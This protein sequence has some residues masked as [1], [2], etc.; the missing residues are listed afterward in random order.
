MINLQLR[1][2]ETDIIVV[3]QMKTMRK[4][5]GNDIVKYWKFIK[6]YT[7]GS[8]VRSSKRQLKTKKTS[9]RKIKSNFISVTQSHTKF[10]VKSRV[11]LYKV[12]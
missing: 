9:R 8:L 11:F 4:N 1:E 12:N 10:I 7:K 6:E 5:L 2:K 3:F